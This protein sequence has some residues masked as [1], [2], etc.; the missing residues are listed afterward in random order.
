MRSVYFKTEA[1]RK[2]KYC[3]NYH[4]EKYVVAAF[5]YGLQT[6]ETKEEQKEG[7]MEGNKMKTLGQ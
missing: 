4:K 7:P 6:R 2:K 5:T 3:I 1:G